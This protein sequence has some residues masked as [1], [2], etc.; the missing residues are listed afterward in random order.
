MIIL[1]SYANYYRNID[2]YRWYFLIDLFT[3]LSKT[4]IRT[5]VK[6]ISSKET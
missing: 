1:F 2:L 5:H 4:K 3:K 6:I